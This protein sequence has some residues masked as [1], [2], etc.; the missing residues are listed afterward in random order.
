VPI[1]TWDRIW[2]D[3]DFYQKYSITADEI[4]LIESIIRPMD[5]DLFNE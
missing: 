4:N 2:G 3:T 5:G 1:Q